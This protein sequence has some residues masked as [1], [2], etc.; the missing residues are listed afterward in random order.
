MLMFVIVNGDKQ[1]GS[2]NHV[3][4]FREYTINTSK[5]LLLNFEENLHEIKKKAFINP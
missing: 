1:V 5:L 2:N 3:S 4:M